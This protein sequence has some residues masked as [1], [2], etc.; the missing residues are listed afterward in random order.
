[1]LCFCDCSDS[2]DSAFVS[3]RRVELRF[4]L[5]EGR[6]ALVV[7]EDG[8]SADDSVPFFVTWEQHRQI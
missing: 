5:T 7:I 2:F 1:M 4:W 6:D 8:D 3:F